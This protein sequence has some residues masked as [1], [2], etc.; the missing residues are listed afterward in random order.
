M[1]RVKRNI[2]WKYKDISMFDYELFGE[3]LNCYCDICISLNLLNSH[4]I[5]KK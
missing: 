4:R 3:I 1:Y 2:P 5:R